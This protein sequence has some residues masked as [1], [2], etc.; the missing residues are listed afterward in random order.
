MGPAEIYVTCRTRL[1]ELAPTLSADQQ[2]AA[3]APTP[4]WTVVDGYRHLAGVCGDMLVGNR[5][6]GGITD[7]AWTAKQLADR[8]DQSLEQVCA[9][10]AERA[11]ELDG[12][13]EAAGAAMGFVALD[14]WT[15]EQDIRAASG[16]GAV[17]D[18]AALPGLLDLTMGNMDRF[19]APQGGPPLRLVLDG[20]ERRWGDGEPTATLVA[21]SYELMR[22]VFG[23]RSQAQVDG[24]DWSGE[25]ADAARAAIRLFPAQPQDLSD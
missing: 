21:T 18:D 1:V 12:M 14:A 3:L 7:T 9:E 6:Q 11:P 22:M 25:G 10:W 5:P 23:R 2:A 15:H 19:Y 20:E 16:V 8:A 13:V 17:H 4:P 24:A